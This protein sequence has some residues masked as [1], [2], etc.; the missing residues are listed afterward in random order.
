M[1]VAGG[2][3]DETNESS[4]S[5]FHQTLYALD[6]TAESPAWE[7]RA[8]MPVARG[9]GALVAMGGGRLLLV[10]GETHARDNRTKVRLPLTAQHVAPP[11]L[12]G[13]QPPATD[14]HAC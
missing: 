10:A 1:Y 9:D 14:M 12:C 8:A 2:Y 13:L 4:P 3:Y 6:T 11:P 5:S 7:E